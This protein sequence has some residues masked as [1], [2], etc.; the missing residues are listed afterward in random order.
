M[1]ISFRVCGV[2]DPFSKAVGLKCMFRPKKKKKGERE[3]SKQYSAIKKN[4]RL[5]DKIK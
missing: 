5:Y 4:K 2:V 1:T 3:I